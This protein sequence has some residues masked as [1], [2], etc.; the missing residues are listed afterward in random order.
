MAGTD[1][2]SGSQGKNSCKPNREKNPVGDLFRLTTIQ[3][4]SERHRF[5]C[6]F[7]QFKT[8]HGSARLGSAPLHTCGQPKLPTRMGPSSFVPQHTNQLPL[9]SQ[10]ERPGGS[11]GCHTAFN[12]G[13]NKSVLQFLGSASD[14]CG[15]GC[16]SESLL[17]L[18]SILVA[19]VQ[20]PYMSPMMLRAKVLEHGRT[21]S[22]HKNKACV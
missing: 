5:F 4:C 21:A 13:V 9:T 7:G 1:R 10:T 16:A 18:P 11:F 3:V 19:A 22:A 14:V 17:W 15:R 2:P 20:S 6:H 12:R 8:I